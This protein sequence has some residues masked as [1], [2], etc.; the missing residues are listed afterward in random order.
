MASTDPVKEQILERADIAEVVGQYVHLKSRGGRLFGLCPFHKEKTPSFSVNAERGFYHCFGCSAGG[1]AIDF[2]MGVENLTYPE[3][4]RM[5]A[6][7]LGIEIKPEH[8]AF[9]QHQEIDRY[10]IMEAA[11]RFYQ[12]N[13]ESSK[14]AMEYLIERGLTAEDIKRFGL[15]FAP[16]G[17]DN[18]LYTIKKNNVP[19]AVMDEL[20]LIIKSNKKDGYYDRFRNRIMFPIRNAIGRVIAF[21]GRAMDPD[22]PAKYLNS[23]ETALF[24]KSKVMY[25]LDQAKTII[26]ERG[27][28]AVEGYM[29]A[30]MLH[31]YGFTQAIATL[32]TA[33]TAE[34]VH[35]LRRYTDRYTLLYDGDSAGIRAARRGVELFFEQ[36]LTVKVAL[37]PGGQ[38]PDDYL[39]KEGVDAMQQLLDHPL[40]G[41][42]FNLLQEMKDRDPSLPQHKS[43]IVDGVTPLLL[44]IPEAFIRNDYVR[45]LAE[46][47]GS[48]AGALQEAINAKASRTRAPQIRQTSEEPPIQKQ[49]EVH[50]TMRLQ[51]E[52][53]VRLLAFQHGFILPE[54]MLEAQR[55]W[56]FDDAE[57]AQVLPEWAAAFRVDSRLDKIIETLLGEKPGPKTEQ[58]AVRLSTL[59]PD[60][61]DASAFLRIIESEGMPNREKE[62]RKM[63][64]EVMAGLQEELNK[65]RWQQTKLDAQADPMQALKALDQ[66]LFAQKDEPAK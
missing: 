56:L 5:L 57:W 32:G 16:P 11:A 37:L 14:P 41:F 50:D 4:R 33:L 23:N 63:H 30:I 3:A 1:N 6:E 42:E 2:V 47:I 12:R 19:E 38:D 64:D 31:K 60:N 15:G 53:L 58:M 22:D 65:R 49:T 44:R 10:Q 61:Q 29:D 34:H 39:R 59:F 54:G 8:G 27:A 43:A 45:M 13:L 24:N 55:P 17:W 21:G 9:R 51:K 36:G 26:K 28:L 20:G 48:D 40:D 46:R 35:L 25:L 52:A 18:L 62:L 7:K 66:Q